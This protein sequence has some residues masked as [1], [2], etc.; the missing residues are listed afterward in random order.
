MFLRFPS[1]FTQFLQKFLHN[2]P[3]ITGFRSKFVELDTYLFKQKQV[4]PLMISRSSRRKKK[5]AQSRRR[6]LTIL[7]A[8]FLA[9]GMYYNMPRVSPAPVGQANISNNSFVARFQPDLPRRDPFAVPSEFQPKPII[10]S[11][12]AGIPASS[13]KAPGGHRVVAPRLTGLV[14]AGNSRSAIIQYG[15]DSRSYRQ[16]AF[17]GPYQVV[18]INDTSAIL[19]GISGTIVLR[20]ER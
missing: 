20:L 1:L 4:S 14:T 13:Y 17:V 16:G 8:V 19:Q 9:G 15:A 12:G 2:Y 10:H 6:L 3:F 18:A 7:T 5:Q 11:F